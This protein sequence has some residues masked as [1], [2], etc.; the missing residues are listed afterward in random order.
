M[1]LREIAERLNCRLE[2]DGDIEIRR[3]AGIEQAQQG[4]LTF[5]P[6]EKKMGKLA[7]ARASA[8]IAAPAVGAMGAPAALL[9]TEH[10]YLAFAHAVG[11]LTDAPVPPKG[12][13]PAS[14]VAP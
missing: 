10:P 13:D 4:G 6:H 2:G 11:L 12:I 3:V 8:V 14:S 5:I 9:L 7:A 1:K